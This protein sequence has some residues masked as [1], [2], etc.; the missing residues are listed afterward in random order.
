MDKSE[1]HMI[2]SDHAMEY[3][4]LV[5]ERKEQLLPAPC[6]QFQNSI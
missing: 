3:S 4:S 1:S 6:R 2:N 5:Q